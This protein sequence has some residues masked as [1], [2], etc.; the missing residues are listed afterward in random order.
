M[1]NVKSLCIERHEKN[2]TLGITI[3]L[4]RLYMAFK[5]SQFFSVHDGGMLVGVLN[6]NMFRKMHEVLFRKEI[7]CA[8]L[9]STSGVAHLR[10]TE[11]NATKRGYAI[12]KC[13]RDQ[14][15]CDDGWKKLCRF[16]FQTWHFCEEGVYKV[17]DKKDG[18]PVMVVSPDGSLWRSAD[19]LV[20]IH[21]KPPLSLK[22]K[23][24]F[25]LH[26]RFQCILRFQTGISHRVRYME[27]MVLQS[28]GHLLLYWSPKNGNS[29][30]LRII[31]F[32]T[33]LYV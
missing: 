29:K 18:T 25:H 16:C 8:T 14:C 13:K 20:D 10:M 4:R 27:Q 2:H 12:W 26:K 31:T 17:Y 9:F 11:R 3:K 23:C 24:L 1:P 21:T 22:I 7:M 30:M 33:H 28:E 6:K 15:R 32:V 5:M 19:G